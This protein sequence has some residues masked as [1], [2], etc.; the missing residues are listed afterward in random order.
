MA[1]LAS[2]K[3]P[4]LALGFALGVS[5]TAR[6]QDLEI[7]TQAS[8][9]EWW[10]GT[11]ALRLGTKVYR[12]TGQTLSEGLCRARFEDGVL[13]PVF[14]GQDP[15]TERMV[16]VVFIGSG[17]LEVQ[18]ERPADA[19][20]FANHR[21][22]NLGE[23]ASDWL[24]LAHQQEPYQVDFDRSLLLTADP[25]LSQLLESLE[26]LEHDIAP[27][28]ESEERSHD[29]VTD[30]G[31][32]LNEARMIGGRLLSIRRSQLQ[33]TGI[34]FE[35]MLHIDR[36]WIDALG[37]PGSQGRMLADFRT[38]ERQAPIESDTAQLERADDRWLS[39]LRDSSHITETGYRSMVFR[40]GTPIEGQ[41]H[42]ELLAGS[43]V[44]TPPMVPR[45]LPVS[46]DVHIKAPPRRRGSVRGAHVKS[47]MRLRAEGGD[48]RGVGMSFPIQ[49]EIHTWKIDSLRLSD[50][51]EIAWIPIGE[52]P[53]TATESLTREDD[54]GADPTR[55]SSE[56]PSAEP[57][58]HG[59]KFKPTT[60]QNGVVWKSVFAVFPEPIPAG[61]EIELEVAWSHEWQF[62]HRSKHRGIRR[63][64][65]GSA[66]GPRVI[67]PE[68]F[69]LPGDT[70]WDFTAE[71][72]I[73][74]RGLE[75][76]A[77]ALSGDTLG[78]GSDG[79]A[80]LW[81]R[82]QGQQIVQPVVSIG[83]WNSRV[84]DPY[85]DGLVVRS[86]LFHDVSPHISPAAS[87]V[88]RILIWLKKFFPDY[89]IGEVDIAQGSTMLPD[90]ARRDGLRYAHSGMVEIRQA[91][92]SM[93]ESPSLRDQNPHHMRL[94]VAS[95]LAYQ[96]WGRQLAPASDRDAWV[97]PALS[98]AYGAFYLHNT[99][100][101][102]AFE[103]HMAAL[104][105]HLEDSSR[106]PSE[107][108]VSIAAARPLSLT[109]STRYSN[110]SPEH[111]A[112]YGAYVLTDMIRLQIGDEAYFRALSMLSRRMARET[113]FTLSTEALRAAFEASSG[114]ELSDFFDFWIHG[115]FIPELALTLRRVD[116]SGVL[117]GCL[118]SSVPFGHIEVPVEI[119]DQDGERIVAPTIDVINGKGS[120]W[121]PDRAD[122]VRVEIDPQR[123]I[124]ASQRQVSW[125][126]EQACDFKD[127]ESSTTEE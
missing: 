124:L 117:H 73:P 101:V 62:I 48:V 14:S 68:L 3:T 98:D 49:G 56:D 57:L 59:R 16:G 11:A 80:W 18:F 37:Y 102:G 112:D 63:V 30:R 118:G 90:E 29:S 113:D 67:L 75:P 39:C 127:A 61:Q 64:N 91:A 107:R 26:P 41:R 108:G 100:G 72:G 126:S 71:V 82:T 87:E 115:G 53:V 23:S 116:E 103:D 6:S 114:T 5:S 89:A 28:L 104:Q 70:V 20:R 1:T 47:T 96:Y 92:E 110:L 121:V 2:H 7:A 105:T 85:W 51:R 58:E 38:T 54:T 32:D 78:D 42:V 81:A 8:L 9:S 93:E 99:V 65:L 111:L 43:P 22:L 40:A 76:S 119:W 31:Q 60:T 125:V 74:I 33:E 46:A 15:V 123:L 44:E 27:E 77:I 69:P 35:S 36:L 25:A 50:G 21:V 88:R 52:T 106:P 97:A 109:G 19:L 45:L 66:T 12:A 24:T 122:D 4:W 95:Q 13:I 10:E 84:S 94:T 55:Y 86:H 79:S 17:E 120:F 83:R 34:E